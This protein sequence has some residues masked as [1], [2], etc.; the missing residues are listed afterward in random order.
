MSARC[1]EAEKKLDPEPGLHVSTLTA[2]TFR[3]ASR[4]ECVKSRS[5]GAVLCIRIRSDPKRRNFWPDPE[6]IISDPSPGSFGSEMNGKLMKNSQFP[7]KMHHFDKILFFQ[8]IPQK[9]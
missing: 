7:S 4:A 2:C 1:W 5:F 9:P 6:K 8:K 3:S